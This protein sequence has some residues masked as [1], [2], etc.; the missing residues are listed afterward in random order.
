M[1]LLTGD[2]KV[3]SL[4]SHYADGVGDLRAFERLLIQ[5][6]DS[7]AWESFRTPN[8]ALVEP[9]SFRHFITA[10]R[11]NGLG[12]TDDKIAALLGNNNDAVVKMRE[13]LK[14]GEQG[15]RTDLKGTSTNNVSRSRNTKQGNSRAY[16]L[17]RLKRER[18]E[19]YALVGAG[20]L[21]ANAAAIQAGFR[22]RTFTVR[23]DPASAAAT[24][25]RRFTPEEVATIAKLLAAEE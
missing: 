5:V 1:S 15:K 6:I 22:P 9:A 23:A 11:Y 19:L 4:Q 24:L 14:G 17:D 2:E 13:L 3:Q 7:G 25:R 16:T 8:G 18:P 10:T 21:T 20:E 12:A